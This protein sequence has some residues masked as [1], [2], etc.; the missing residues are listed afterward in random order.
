[1]DI[2]G[3]NG[4]KHV[5]MF[6][7][8]LVPTMEQFEELSAYFKE[9]YIYM[10]AFNLYESRSPVTALVAFQSALDDIG[11]LQETL[12]GASLLRITDNDSLYEVLRSKTQECSPS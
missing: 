11:W 1:M 4:P 6:T 2:F 12:A 3:G 7:F 9:R 10:M 8:K 5:L